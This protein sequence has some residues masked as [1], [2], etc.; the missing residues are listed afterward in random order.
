[1]RPMGYLSG[2]FLRGVDWKKW[3]RRLKLK[4]VWSTARARLQTPPAV[5]RR[6]GWLGVSPTLENLSQ[7]HL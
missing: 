4:I 7:T 3:R 6:I 2:K 5:E 1:M